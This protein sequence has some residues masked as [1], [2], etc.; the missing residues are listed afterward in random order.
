MMFENM[1]RDWFSDENVPYN[2]FVR[3]LLR[4]GS[5]KST[6]NAKADRP[7]RFSMDSTLGETVA[8][9]LA[10]ERFNQMEPGMLDGPMI[11]FA[12]GMTLAE[13]IGAA[14][15]AKPMYEAVVNALNAE[16]KINK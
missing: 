13:L 16:C 14:P 3:A 9:P 5:S 2:E 10:V 12:Y 6:L 4:V 8:E 11:Q 15:Q 1:I 7:E